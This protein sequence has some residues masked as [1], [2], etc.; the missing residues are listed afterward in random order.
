MTNQSIR[1]ASLV[2]EEAE[3]ALQPGG[4]KSGS[5]AAFEGTEVFAKG[6]V[7]NAFTTTA[8]VAVPWLR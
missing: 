2:G 4:A 6:S 7:H 5:G 8:A 1:L 3:S